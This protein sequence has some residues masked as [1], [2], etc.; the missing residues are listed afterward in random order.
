MPSA[1][2]SKGTSLGR[3]SRLAVV[4]LVQL[5]LEEL[6]AKIDLATNKKK[7]GF[8]TETQWITFTWPLISIVWPTTLDS[9]GT[10][11]G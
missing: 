11:L 7:H 9:F 8:K 10:E 5:N 4:G 2:F 3:N 6:F 1:Y